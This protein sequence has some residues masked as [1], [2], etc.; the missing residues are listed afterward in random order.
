MPPAVSSVE[1]RGKGLGKTELESSITFRGGNR[2]ILNQI[3]D[4]R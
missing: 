3:L 2:A 4:V 1:L